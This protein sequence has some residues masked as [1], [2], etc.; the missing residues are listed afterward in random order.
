[1]SEKRCY[2]VKEVQEILG[3]GRS[4]VYKLL[5]RNEFRS[6]RLAGKHLI[7]KESFENWM[8]DISGQA[9]AT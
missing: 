3:I 6:I 9:Q 2:T 1:M 5:R 4:S 8:K 7:I